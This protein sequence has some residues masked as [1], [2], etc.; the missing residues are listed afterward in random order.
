[1]N[2]KYV[3][4][5]GHFYQPPREDAS[6]EKVAVQKSASPFHDWNHR[7]TAECYAANAQA[8]RLDANDELIKLVNNYTFISFNFGPTL[9]S[10]MQ[11]QAPAAYAAI[12]EADRASLQHFNGHG[13]ALAQVYNHMIMPLAN[14]KDKVTQ[15]IWGLQDF[16]S[17]FG[18]KAKGIWLAETA[19]DEA[20][21]EVL[22]DH[23][24]EFTILAPR[25]A[26]AVRAQADADW[27]HLAHAAIDP[28]RAY[29]CVLKSG[30]S[31]QLF[32]YD[33][34]LSQ[35]VAFE[36]LL[37]DGHSFAKRIVDSL[38]DDDTVELAHIATDGESYGHHHKKGE[39]ALAH[40]LELLQAD[41]TVELC[42][43]SA[44]LAQQ[45]AEWEVQIHEESS[46][47]CVHGVERWRS[48]CGCQ[49]GGHPHWQQAWRQGLRTSLDWLR[50]QLIQVYEQYA[51]PLL[52]DP[53]AARNDYIKVVLDRSDQS[54]QI[55]LT[56]HACKM[57]AKE[58]EI[59]V[60]QLLEMQR[61]AMLMYTS[62]AWFF[63]EVS[64]IETNQ[65]LQYAHKAMQYAQ[66]VAGLYLHHLFEARLANIP[67]N[68]YRTALESY[69]K[70]VLDKHL[71]G[72]D[73]ARYLAVANVYT[74]ASHAATDI[75]HQV[76]QLIYEEHQ[77]QDDS[78]FYIGQMRIRSS[79]DLKES[80][81]SFFIWLKKEK[82][83]GQVLMDMS[84]ADYELAKK[85]LLRIYNSP[86]VDFTRHLARCLQQPNFDLKDLL[87]DQRLAL[88]THFP[89]WVLEEE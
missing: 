17:R 57:L 10:W 29:R 14:A 85:Q 67:S 1:M 74:Q 35:A 89:D 80:F 58:E 18:R 16:E 37:H 31:I 83:Q 47:S 51:S 46:W 23:G 30:R 86:N 43:Y 49:T 42:N 40:C 60:R 5:H 19:V 12:R 26:K 28:K 44:F 9:L 84:V 22:L 38:T 70:Y 68:K 73:I 66:S 48:N 50:D 8:K 27:Q 79:V 6:L 4:I 25:Q 34:P 55:F 7:I 21:L 65:V 62:C 87:E 56:Q 45:P 24:I 72:V 52:S 13:S 75:Q 76:L 39:M 33:G 69:Q 41:E 11:N 2:K 64:R 77:S 61:Q 15:V 71:T 82:L 63:D 59:Q 36:G 32:F 53:W 88:Q 20:T 78:H 81:F 3:C 54:W